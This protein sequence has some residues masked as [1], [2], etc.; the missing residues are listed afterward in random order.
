MSKYE[1][2]RRYL[3]AAGD[4]PLTMTFGEVALIVDVLPPSAF[5]HREWWSNNPKTTAPRNA[6]LPAGRRISAVDMKGQLVSFSS[7]G[8]PE[9]HTSYIQAPEV[10]RARD[11]TSPDSVTLTPDQIRSLEAFLTFRGESSRLR[12]RIAEVE[13]SVRGL[14]A[15]EALIA[16]SQWGVDQ[17]LLEGAR[18]AKILA[19]QVDVVLHAAGILHALPYVLEPGEI[20]ESVSLG[21][22]N[23]GRAHDV[24]TDRRIAEFKFI[25]WAGGAETVRQDTLL[26]DIFNLATAETSKQKV[27]YVTGGDIPLHWLARSRRATR[28]CLA[29]KRRTPARFDE[30]YGADAFH[31]VCD[32]WAAVE[33]TVEVVDL[34]PLVPGLAVPPAGAENDT[35]VD[36]T[37]V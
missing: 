15:S 24:E 3:E 21:A 10:R 33:N 18:L 26:I 1:P 16:A 25:N 36:G 7:P 29:R 35:E 12:Q 14:T 2:L 17:P 23:T 22:G 30:R 5:R 27:M 28:E 19:A 8:N 34:T 9:R 6:W 20:V 11:H 13:R 4:Q 32:Y 37:P 31:Y